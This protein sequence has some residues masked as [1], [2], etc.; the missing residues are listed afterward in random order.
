M[1][2]C[3][4]EDLDIFFPVGSAGPALWQAQRAT[5]ICAG[6][7]VTEECLSYALRTGQDHGIWGGLTS[8]E[9]RGLRRQRERG[10]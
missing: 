1:A 9:R 4:G 10:A 6:C 8:E 7:P 3:E 2:A 5:S